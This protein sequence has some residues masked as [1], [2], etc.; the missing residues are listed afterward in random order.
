MIKVLLVDDQMLFRE[1]MRRV[2]SDWNDFEVVGEASNGLEAFKLSKE[3]LPDIV[4]M[5]VHMPVMSGVESTRHIRKELASVRVVMLTVS[6]DEKDLYDAIKNGAQGYILKD[7]PVRR[8]HSQLKGVM[9]DDAPLSGPIAAKMLAEFRQLKPSDSS[10][11]DKLMAAALEPLTER[12]VDVLKLIAE[13]LSNMEIADRL[14]VSE[15]TVKKHL[16]N[17]LQKLQLNNRVQAA[18]YAIRAGLVK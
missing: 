7:T 8:L 14:V 10:E 3:L 6:D 2:F 11:W 4:L 1:G 15:Q 16:H 13:G 17:T 12:E 5:D 18:V 9:E